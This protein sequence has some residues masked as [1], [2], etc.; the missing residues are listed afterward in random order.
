MHPTKHSGLL[1][2]HARCDD[3]GWES[4]AKNAAGNAAQHAGRTGHTVH[5]EQ[6]IGVTYNKKSSS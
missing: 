1:A 3:C 6:T 5:V 2:V 4:E